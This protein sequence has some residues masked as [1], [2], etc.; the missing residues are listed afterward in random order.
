M[1]SI[2]RGTKAAGGTAFAA[3]TTALAS[4]VNTDFDRIYNEFNT[5]IQNIN[6][7][8]AAAILGTK[9]AG[10]AANAAA[11]QVSEDPFPLEVFASR[12]NLTEEIRSLRFVIEQA[13]G[14]SSALGNFWFTD[15]VMF[16]TGDCKVTLKATADPGWV[17]MDTDDGTIGNVASSATK[18]ADA[19]TEELFELLFD[20]ENIANTGTITS[21]SANGG[22]ITAI[23][24]ANPAV[25]TTVDH[26]LRDGDT[27]TIVGSNVDHLA[28][29]FPS[30]ENVD[31]TFAITRIDDDSFS[32]PVSTDLAGVAPFGTWRQNGSVPA[33]RAI[34]TDV[35]HGLS[36][37]DIILIANDDATPT[38][39]G[40]HT[41]Q[42][43]NAN[44]FAVNVTI[45]VFGTTGD[46]IRN[47]L[48]DSGANIIAKTG[49]AQAAF[50]ANRRIV[51]PIALGRAI[52]ISGAGGGVR[53]DDLTLTSRALG[54]VDGKEDHI[55][56]VGELA[57]H[58]HHSPFVQS[59]TGSGG[60]GIPGA[61]IA[62]PATG[63]PSP[64]ESD[65]Q[66]PNGAGHTSMQPSFFVNV[67]IKL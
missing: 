54:A 53:G 25:I 38:I 17:L 21:I 16:S 10:D 15:A 20:N 22:T 2:N 39:N 34:I 24:A 60:G 12:A 59:F 6:I 23:T 51:L 35:A 50:D 40:V 52:A 65:S 14:Q 13:F 27:I 3:N 8:D 4:E 44:Q 57:E 49:T 42:V 67:M 26:G 66:T 58:R 33:A 29:T 63:P 48:Q 36:T 41:V 9:L 56:S 47:F 7:A 1:G 30:R 11:A 43:I 32:V 46:W 61:R 45:T 28:P 19:D 18:R 31:G 64:E 62:Q 37:G 5:N 55:L